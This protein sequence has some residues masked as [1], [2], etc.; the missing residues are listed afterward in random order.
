MREQQIAGFYDKDY[1]DQPSSTSDVI[2]SS[3]SDEELDDVTGSY[4]KKA[5]NPFTNT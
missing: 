4:E 1:E 5:D 3:S 2:S